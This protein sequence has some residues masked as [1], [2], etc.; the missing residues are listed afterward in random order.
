MHKKIVIGLAPLLAVAA[1][2]VTSA[3][4]VAYS[5]EHVYCNGELPVDGTCPPNGSSEDAHLELNYANA[6]GQS[7]ETCDD[8]YLSESGY[9]GQACMYY[10]SE[11]A[12]ISTS[13]QYGYPRAWNGGSIQHFVYAE[14]Y[15]YHTGDSVSAGEGTRQLP[16][17]VQL[18]SQFDSGLDSSSVLVT[19]GAASVVSSPTDVC[20]LDAEKGSGGATAGVC[21][22]TSG[23]EE[24]GLALT[25]ENSAGAPV[26]LGLTPSGNTSVTVTNTDG[27]TE[28]VPVTNNVYEITSG[29]PSTATLKEASGKIT[30]R[31]LPQWS[32]PPAS[33]APA[34]SAAH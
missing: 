27:T 9:T 32:R 30:T 23:V 31:H 15:G 3:P 19:G 8:D 26:V 4:A 16:P 33:S 18:L 25:T 11:V 6:G 7:H 10:G 5:Y 28:T 14:E 34:G 20:L 22:T 1:M 2:A 12:T 21:G 24:R 13:G 17:V 29:N